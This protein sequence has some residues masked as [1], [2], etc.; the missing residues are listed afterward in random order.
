MGWARIDDDFPNHPKVW[1]VG[2]DG[3]AL[4]LEGLCHSAKFLTDG[5]LKREDVDRMRLVKRPIVT[6][7]KLVEVGLWEQEGEDF[8]IHDYHDYNPTSDAVRDRR[9][10]TRK[11]VQEHRKHVCN[12]VT[13]TTS[14]HAGGQPR[15]GVRDGMGSSA[16]GF[17]RRRHPLDESPD[18]SLDAE[19]CGRAEQ[20]IVRFSFHHAELVKS[21]YVENRD[22]DWPPSLRLVKAYSDREL[23]AV[24]RIYLVATGPHFEG[25]PRTIGRLAEA[26]PMIEA[27]MRREGQWPSA[28]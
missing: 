27:Q 13:N 21:R 3:V 20:L 16:L 22:R 26:A 11:R 8:R 1:R 9:E 2:T 24:T 19:L 17:G 4:F 10:S 18:V 12:A 6:A 25:K 28:A 23:D 15:A 7:A 14:T 5:L